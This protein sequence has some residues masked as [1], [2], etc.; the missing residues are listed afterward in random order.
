MPSSGLKERLAELIPLKQKEIKDFRTQHDNTIVESFTV[1]QVS[2]SGWGVGVRREMKKEGDAEEENE[3]K[4]M[5]EEEE[6]GN[7]EE[8]EEKGM[9]EE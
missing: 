5:K 8:N 4:G 6:G 3:E 9:K 2:E 7:E 1:E